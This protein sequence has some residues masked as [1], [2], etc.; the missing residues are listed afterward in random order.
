MLQILAELGPRSTAF[1]IPVPSVPKVALACPDAELR[2]FV[3]VC[4]CVP[5]ARVVSLRDRCT[6]LLACTDETCLTK[7]PYKCFLRRQAFN[8]MEDVRASDM[9]S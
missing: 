1:M 3:C 4:L 2:L 8:N 7:R 6:C 5:V 9:Q